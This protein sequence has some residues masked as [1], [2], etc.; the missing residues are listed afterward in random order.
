MSSEENSHPQ[1]TNWSN[2]TD[3]SSGQSDSW[4]VTRTTEFVDPR[5]I[6][7]TDCSELQTMDAF[8]LK[9]VYQMDEQ[10]RKSMKESTVDVVFKLALKEFRA[11]LIF[12]HSVAA[13]DGHLRLTY[14]NLIDHF[15]Q[16]IRSVCQKENTWNS[17]PVIM[18][19]NAF[20]GY[21]DELRHSRVRHS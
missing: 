13:Q 2:A 11:N 5:D 7:I 17:F 9:K 16:M 3:A 10:K 15:E 21:L 19:V 18:G 6:L 4:L 14:K 8:I 1:L 20:R 12:T